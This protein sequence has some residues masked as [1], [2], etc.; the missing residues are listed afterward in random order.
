MSFHEVYFVPAAAAADAFVIGGKKYESQRK[1][2]LET[3]LVNI[4]KLPEREIYV[5]SITD[6]LILCLK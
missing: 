5:F 1:K 4:Y 6:L 2:K 3:K